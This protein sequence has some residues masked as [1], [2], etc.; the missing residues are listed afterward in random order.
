LNTVEQPIDIVLNVCKPIGWTSFDVVRWFKRKY[1][2][3]KIG[4]A[5]T[6]DPFA[7]GVLLVCVGKA[8]KRIQELVVEKKEYITTIEFGVET[9]TLDI[10]GNILRKKNTVD[11]S[12]EMVKS[13][14]DFFIGEIQQVPPIFSAVKINGRRAYEVARKG[15]TPD[16]KPRT[17]KI[18]KFE[19]KQLKSNTAVFR[20]VCSKGTYIRSLAKDFS[21]KLGTVGFLRKLTR[22]RIGPFD[23]KDSLKL[24]EDY[25]PNNPTH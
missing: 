4:H 17:V 8:T 13:Q 15:A 6:L 18:D 3:Q 7:D 12:T 25:S 21:E 16:M 20:I 10:S 22:T 1:P 24:K 2:N 5:G 19:L 11:L 9:D 14:L 23:I